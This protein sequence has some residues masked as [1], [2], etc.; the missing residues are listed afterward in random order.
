M[1]IDQE[2][3]KHLDWIESVVSLLGRETA[4][5]KEIDAV[6]RHDLCELGRW[7]ESEES[8]KYRDFEE[9]GSLKEQHKLF[10]AMAGELILA[11][12]AGNEQRAVASQ[13]KFIAVS[14]QVVG[15]L[16][17]LRDHSVPGG[18]TRT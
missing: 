12:E 11:A 3:M 5:R 14:Q 18:N 7:L 15:L 10:H 16:T 4:S 1:D 6:S 2:I 9:F 17:A 13:E 8:D